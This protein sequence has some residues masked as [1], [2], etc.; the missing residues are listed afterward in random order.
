M[1]RSFSQ[2]VNS[3]N[4]DAPPQETDEEVS[5]EEEEVMPKKKRKV[6]AKQ[7]KKKAEEQAKKR[8]AYVLYE[9]MDTGVL[10]QC[11]TLRAMA[12]KTSLC[13]RE[14]CLLYNKQAKLK[15]SNSIPVVY[16][17]PANMVK[18]RSGRVY[19]YPSM[20]SLQGRL[21]R[22]CASEYYRD[23]DIRK[24]APTCMVY[25]AR[26][27][28]DIVC[29]ILQSYVRD[30]EA[31]IQQLQEL[32]PSL[33]QAPPAM[34]KKI[35]NVVMH[36]GAYG[37]IMHEFGVPVDDTII[38]FELFHNEVHAIAN[39]AKTHPD[40][41][42]LWTI[43]QTRPGPQA[44]FV[45]FIW[46]H[47]EGLV[48]RALVSFFENTDTPPG[49]LKHDG[50]MVY[51]NQPI[52]EYVLLDAQ[53]HVKLLTGVTVVLVEKS[54]EPTPEDFAFLR[55]PRLLH[56]I[57]DDDSKVKHLLSQHAY[58]HGHVRLLNFRGVSIL[59]PHPTMPGVFRDAHTDADERYFPPPFLML[60]SHFF[61]VRLVRYICDTI[62]DAARRT[63]TYKPKVIK[64]WLT[65]TNETV[66]PMLYPDSFDAKVIAFN[67]G[68]VRI[69]GPE[70]RIQFTSWEQDPTP[71]FKTRHFVEQRIDGFSDDGLK[72]TAAE[73]PL[74]T[75]ILVKQLVT[76][77]KDGSPDTSMIEWF[78]GFVGR[79]Q[80]DVRELD[81]WQKTIAI[82]GVT[83]TGKSSLLK[84]ISQ[85]FP[86]DLRVALAANFE[87]QFGFSAL[88]SAKVIISPETPKTLP[89]FFEPAI[90]QSMITGD[91]VPIPIKYGQPRSIIWKTPAIWAGND[92]FT[93]PDKMGQIARRVTYFVFEKPVEA[94]D[95]SMAETIIAQELPTVMMRC[96]FR[97]FKLLDIV[98]NGDVDKFLPPSLRHAQDELSAFTNP[99]ECFIQNGSEYYKILQIEGSETKLS[100]LESA[101]SNYMEFGPFK[102]KGQTIG[103]DYYPLLKNGFKVVSSRVCKVCDLKFSKRNCGSHWALSNRKRLFVVQNM[104]L[105][106]LKQN[107]QNGISFG[108]GFSDSGFSEPSFAPQPND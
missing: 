54:L 28:L 32:H 21:V 101:F 77:N 104:Q 24:C 46:Q 86:R 16:K 88:A 2:G 23:I 70:R 15:M 69:H 22:L 7:K 71:S 84:V 92:P 33:E 79:L 39:K 58:K 94:R 30:P 52:T 40:F 26:E 57:K 17:Y 11:M 9:Q 66:F 107:R 90:F 47:V 31:Y 96:I 89:Q 18:L 41:E 53:T 61:F 56:M 14:M 29:P 13:A 43:A 42:P 102:Q 75:E 1:Q 108:S 4:D 97:Y 106:A 93:F 67:N 105:V 10:N 87:K 63:I 72:Y 8:E 25:I 45:S 76:E 100:E 44:S 50:L 73:T 51:G 74:W 80:F 85:M 62:P 27:K 91:E 81:N 5:S 35:F 98:N 65:T 12:A 68:Y 37:P 103:R 38:E 78:E 49:V 95:T 34:F 19:A 6:S 99:L 36:G 64:D 59:E 60:Y 55:G 20:Q 3:S 82:I 83:N 48:L